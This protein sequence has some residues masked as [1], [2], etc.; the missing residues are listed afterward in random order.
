V[1]VGNQARYFLFVP[2]P[3]QELYRRSGAKD[4]PCANFVARFL[5]A[6]PDQCVLRLRVD[7]GEAYIAP[8]E[9]M[10]HDAST[11]PGL[12]EDVHVTGRGIFNPRR[13]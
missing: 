12:S 5:E 4:Q 11:L 2:L 1:N 10:V 7:P 3:F 9:S 13:C 6:N 8:T